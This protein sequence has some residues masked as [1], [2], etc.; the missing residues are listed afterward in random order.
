[1]NEQQELI[2]TRCVDARIWAKEF[3]RITKNH[4]SWHQNESYM[5]GWFA[6]ALIAAYE[7]YH[8][9]LLDRVKELEQQ[10]DA[11][12]RLAEGYMATLMCVMGEELRDIFEPKEGK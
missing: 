11:A 2:L 5:I 10:H 4:P 3:I 6:N 8:S 9:R 1:M 7:V 12:L